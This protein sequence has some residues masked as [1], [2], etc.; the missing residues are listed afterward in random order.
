MILIPMT[1]NSAD[2]LVTSDSVSTILWSA[3]AGIIAFLLMV[4]MALGVSKWKRGKKRNCSY[5]LNKEVS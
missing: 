1:F 5:Q 4:I 3:S 2:D